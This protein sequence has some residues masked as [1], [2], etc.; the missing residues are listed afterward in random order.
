MSLRFGTKISE[1]EC[2]SGFYF[3]LFHRIR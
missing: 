3:A 1:L 2:R